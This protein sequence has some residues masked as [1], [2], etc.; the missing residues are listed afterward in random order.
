[1]LLNANTPKKVRQVFK[2][3]FFVAAIFF[4]FVIM[5]IFF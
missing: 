3:Y 5:P 4:R 2:Q 1:M